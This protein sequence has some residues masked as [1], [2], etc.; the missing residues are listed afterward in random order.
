MWLTC[1][2]FV[3][4]IASRTLATKTIFN[5]FAMLYLLKVNWSIMDLHDTSIS[6][7]YVLF[8]NVCV[9]T[10]T[11]PWQIFF[12]VSVDILWCLSLLFWS[13]RSWL[14]PACIFPYTF[15]NNICQFS[16]TLTSGKD[17]ALAVIQRMR[18]QIQDLREQIITIGG[19]LPTSFYTLPMHP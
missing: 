16:Q 9:N 3:Q 7:L 15:Y 4:L 12:T 1:F 2:P 5:C 14:L 13:W 11:Q 6:G 10:K 19:F 17:S 18:K 8:L